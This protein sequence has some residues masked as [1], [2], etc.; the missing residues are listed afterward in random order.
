MSEVVLNAQTAGE[1]LRQLVN[2]VIQQIIAESKKIISI[3]IDDIILEAK[4]DKFRLDMKNTRLPISRASKDLQT[5]AKNFIKEVKEAENELVEPIHSEE[6]RVQS[7]LDGNKAERQ[8]IKDKKER[9]LIE[10]FNSRCESLFGLGAQFT[11]DYYQV[12]NLKV[13]TERISESTETEW[14]DI[15]EKLKKEMQRL[16]DIELDAKRELAESKAKILDLEKRLAEMEA[17]RIEEQ[18]MKPAIIE[19]ETVKIEKETKAPE[20]VGADPKTEIADPKTE[21]AEPK[22]EIA[23]PILETAIIYTPRNDRSEVETLTRIETR[24]PEFNAGFNHCKTMVLDLLNDNSIKTSPQLLER[25]KQLK[26]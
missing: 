12:G 26:P 22:T 20:R 21:I 4:A 8:R 9:Q 16:K 5:H 24:T 3:E 13:K 19:K 23:A 1:Q 25:L 18:K 17:E 14:A 11:G 6:K 2:P 10:R 15:I 7:L